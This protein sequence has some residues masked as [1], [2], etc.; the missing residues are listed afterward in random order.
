MLIQ[1][2]RSAVVCFNVTDKIAK[3]T[4]GFLSLAFIL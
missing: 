4:A 3:I 2:L 1:S